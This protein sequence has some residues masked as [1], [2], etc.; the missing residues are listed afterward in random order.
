M[1]EIVVRAYPVPV[2]G[3]VCGETLSVIVMAPVLEPVAAGVK[4]TL[5]VQLVLL[6]RLAGQL[7]VWAKSPLPVM[8]ILLIL[9]PLLL[10]TV[11]V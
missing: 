1:T 11:T 4:V 2:R 3:T 6:P 5:T 10:A 7:L 8:T 9:L